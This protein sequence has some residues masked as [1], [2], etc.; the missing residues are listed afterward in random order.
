MKEGVS[1]GSLRDLV[2]QLEAGVPLPPPP[3]P[4]LGE[5][6]TE[7]DWLAMGDPGDWDWQ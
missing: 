2:D 4:S 6:F 7:E 3:G 1:S 5:R